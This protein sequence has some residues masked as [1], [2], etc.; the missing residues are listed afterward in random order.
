MVILYSFY[1][2]ILLMF[3]LFYFGFENTFT[4]TTLYESYL[5]TLW[6]VIFTLLPIVAYGILE[7][8][9]SAETVL[10]NPAVYF[11]GQKRLGFNGKK[12]LLWVFTAIFHSCVAYF[13]TQSLVTTAVQSGILSADALTTDSLFVNGSLTNFVCVIIVNLKL[14]LHTNYWTRWTWGFLMFSIGV[15]LVF[16][17]VYSYMVRFCSRWCFCKAF[18]HACNPFFVRL[19]LQRETFVLSSALQSRCSLMRRPSRYS[20]PA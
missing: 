13:L 19:D 15:W 20:V 6:N 1:K 18:I 12:M 14:A 2:N 9:L 10:R 11:D 8:D 4:G 7:Q 17:A 3:T 16:V 5:G